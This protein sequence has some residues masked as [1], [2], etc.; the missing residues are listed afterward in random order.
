[1][2]ANGSGGMISTFHHKRILMMAHHVRRC[3]LVAFGV[4]LLWHHADGFFPQPCV[5]GLSASSSRPSCS[6]RSDGNRN[7]RFGCHQRHL[8][9]MTELGASRA[10]RGGD[11]GDTK[12][13]KQ[14]RRVLHSSPCITEPYCCSVWRNHH[15][16]LA[17][18]RSR[19]GT[20]DILTREDLRFYAAC[21]HEC[22]CL[23][24]C[25]LL[26]CLFL[27]CAYVSCML[28]A[29]LYYMRAL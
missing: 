28:Y 18:C 1:M 22:V 26:R 9:K 29:I 6:V 16:A 23:V 11:D 14:V 4:A 21:L 2:H 12:R 3:S 25:P 8:T 24:P 27:L 5:L 13:Q 19:Y 7:L 17:L 10:S 15:R 20:Y